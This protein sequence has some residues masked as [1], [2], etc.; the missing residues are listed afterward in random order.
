VAMTGRL[1]PE[2]SI[3]Y[4][5]AHEEPRLGIVMPVVRVERLDYVLVR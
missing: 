1:V 4:D 5:F 3:I 2:E